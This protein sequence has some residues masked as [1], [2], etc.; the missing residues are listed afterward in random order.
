LIK[1]FK[2]TPVE[3]L[4][5]EISKIAG[6]IWTLVTALFLFTAII[7]LFKIEWWWILLI[8]SC[9]LSQILIVGYWKDAKFGTIANILLIIGVILYLNFGL[10]L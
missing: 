1:A 2:I 10:N 3:M 6:V 9:T 7:Y 4:T 5:L 8:V